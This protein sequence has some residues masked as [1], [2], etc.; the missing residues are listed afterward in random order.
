MDAKL[1]EM[2]QTEKSLETEAEALATLAMAE[3]LAS[4]EDLDVDGMT[5]EQAEELARAV[6]AD[7][8]DEEAPAAEEPEDDKA[9]VEEPADEKTA[10]AQEKVAEAEHFGRVMAHA[11]VN[12]RAKIAA[13]AAEKAKTASKKDG[14][15]MGA[16]K[17]K[18]ASAEETEPQEEEVSSLDRL[19]Y[20]RAQEILKEN[21]VDTEQEKNSSISEDQAR[22]LAEKVNARAVEML[23]AE[24]Y[25]FE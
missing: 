11:F 13:A 17:S 22:M 10:S 3:K 16:L 1:A 8:D 23:E 24:G 4:A 5:D 21:G 9:A 14:K 20:A 18:K 12:E 19:A 7:S 25:E 6:L 15:V 2:Y